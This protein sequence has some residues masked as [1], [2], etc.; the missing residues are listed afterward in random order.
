MSGPGCWCWVLGTAPVPGSHTKATEGYTESPRMSSDGSA[1]TPGTQYLAPMQSS[2]APMQ[3]S[4]GT[5][6]PAVILHVNISLGGLPKRPISEGEITPLGIRGDLHAHP[7]IH[8]G[9]DKAIL[10]IA[11]EIVDELAARGYP[12]FCG[13]LGENLTTRGLDF[14]QLRLGQQLRAGSAMLEITRPRGPC[15]TLDIYGPS[16][17]QEIYDERVKAGDPGSPKWGMS[18][19]YARV[20]QP[21]VVRPEDI[22][23]VAATLA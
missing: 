1:L 5:Q 3:S 4:P 8:G 15:A 19:F 17:K 12:L 20:I 13:A 11:S 21:G 2:P 10:I 18:G 16:L 7:N 22:I 14:R 23:S 6:D 9:I